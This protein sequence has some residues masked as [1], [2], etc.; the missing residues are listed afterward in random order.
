[1]PPR[2][3]PAHRE[4]IEAALPPDLR[5][6]LEQMRA[7]LD[8]QDWTRVPLFQPFAAVAA[9]EH[10]AALVAAGCGYRDALLRTSAHLG[11]PEETLRSWTRRWPRQSRRGVHSAPHTPERR[12]VSWS[13]LVADAAAALEEDSARNERSARDA[14]NTGGH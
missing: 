1:M 14:L 11:I 10:A 2:A 12:R 9:V 8:V 13:R 6:A 5:A 7:T 4:A 3:A